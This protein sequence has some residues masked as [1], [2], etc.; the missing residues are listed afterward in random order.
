MLVCVCLF[1]IE[2]QTARLIGMK[3]GTE[4]VLE[5]G[6][7]SWGGGFNMIPPPSGYGVH[8]GGLG[9]LWSLSRAFW[10]KL[11]RTKVVG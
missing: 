7:G 8:K 2:I 4:V 9:C 6:E 3:F 11:N 5:G 1:S 10:Q